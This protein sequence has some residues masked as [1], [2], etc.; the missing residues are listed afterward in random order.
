MLEGQ[1]HDNKSL[2]VV[3]GPKPD[4]NALA[5]DCVG[6][7]NAQGGTLHIGIEDGESAPPETQVVSDSLLERVR[8]RIS[9]LTVNVSVSVY[10][11]RHANE[12]ELL[13][14]KVAPARQSLAARTDGRYYIRISDDTKPV[15]PEDLL[16]LT[17]EK[18]AYIWET[19]AQRDVEVDR[20]DKD[21]WRSFRESIEGSDRV[22]DFVKA[23][24][25]HELLEHYLF[26]DGRNLTNLGVLWVGQRA[27]RARLQYAPTIQYIRYDMDGRKIDKRVWNDYSLNPFQLIEAVWREVPEWREGDEVSDGLFRRRIP[28][29]DEVVVRELLANAL[30]HRPYTSSGDIFINMYPDCMELHN[31][32]L[33]PLGVS[34]ENILHVTAKRNVHLAK[35]FYDLKLM[36]Q[37]GSGYD[38]MYETLLA[39]AK[40]PPRVEE[41]QDRVVVTVESRIMSGEVVRFLD[42]VG[43]RFALR[44]KEFIALGLLAQHDS[45]TSLEFGR[46]LELPDQSERLRDW[47]GRLEEFELVKATGRTKARRY[48]VDFS[49]A[50]AEAFQGPTTLRS[51]E[52]HRLRE[53]LVEDIRRH[54]D[55]QRSSIHE[56]VGPEIP[57][58][59]IQ[60]E[61]KALR[62]KGILT[63]K[64]QKRGS[65]YVLTQSM[66]NNRGKRA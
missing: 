26:A 13:E 53:L 5:G 52:P 18:S 6:F 65:R 37:E 63:L 9:E 62:E 12:G 44:Q 43:K 48:Q 27:D 4:W 1:L 21:Q 22:S 36:E 8:K 35:V 20:L 19:A 58:S 29:Y 11:T 39:A 41:G 33:L 66:A 25:D 54:P 15:M 61:L 50:E 57:I 42:Q 64:G 55:S 45:L 32:G 16:R 7:A 3:Q 59:Q 23:K 10:K 2:R 46:L 30:V 14:V 51:I 34:P 24:S 47:V 49:A 40:P 17:A 28:K 38:R 60:K 56:R 31:P